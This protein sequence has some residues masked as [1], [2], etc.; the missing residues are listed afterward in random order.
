MQ[1]QTQIEH[2][3]YFLIQ[4][5]ISISSKDKGSK[6]YQHILL[7]V[8]NKMVLQRKTSTSTQALCQ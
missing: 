1:C 4:L 6:D 8:I 7:K 2:F 5:F 3:K